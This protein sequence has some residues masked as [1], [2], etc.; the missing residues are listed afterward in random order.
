M[1]LPVAVAL[2]LA[3]LHPLAKAERALLRHAKAVN[4]GADWCSCEA[5]FETRVHHWEAS[6]QLHDVARQ[7][8]KRRKACLSAPNPRRFHG[9]VPGSHDERL[10]T[11]RWLA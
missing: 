7:L 11:A 2:L 4:P 10:F 8:R 5:C 3:R 6:A 9:V 1:R